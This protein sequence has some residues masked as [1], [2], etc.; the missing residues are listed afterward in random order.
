[1]KNKYALTKSKSNV[2][3]S[4]GLARR[5]RT[6]IVSGIDEDIVRPRNKKAALIGRENNE[7]VTLAPNI[8]LYRYPKRLNRWLQSQNRLEERRKPLDAN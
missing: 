2:T 5:Q 8:V 6:R 4:M 7:A 3:S 1:M